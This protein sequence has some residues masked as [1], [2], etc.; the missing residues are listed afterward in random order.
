MK[1]N[2]KD[3]HKETIGCQAMTRTFLS[4]IQLYFLEGNMKN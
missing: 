2:S 4:S 1:D 3:V